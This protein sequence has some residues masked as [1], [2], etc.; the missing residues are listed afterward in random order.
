MWICLYTCCTVKGIHLDLVLDIRLKEILIIL[1]P[2]E[3]F[4]IRLFQITGK[5]LHLQ[6]RCFKLP[7]STPVLHWYRN[8]VVILTQTLSKKDDRP[9]NTYLQ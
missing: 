7:G 2:G 1:H 8:G 3:V 4:L 5:H 6:P 9:G